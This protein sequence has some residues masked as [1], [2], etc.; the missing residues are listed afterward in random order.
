MRFNILR[1][2]TS[3]EPSFE[4]ELDVLRNHFEEISTRLRAEGSHILASESELHQ[5]QEQ[6][7]ELG[8]ELDS[9]RGRARFL[10]H[11]KE[12]IEI[13]IEQANRDIQKV[14]MEL[15]DSR[16]QIE[17][18]SVLV[19]SA[20]LKLEEVTSKCTELEAQ[21][22]RM[23]Q[24]Q[25][26]LSERKIVDGKK[27]EEETKILNNLY[28]QIE[29]LN[30]KNKVLT[31][32]C[33]KNS[34]E[35][36]N[37]S[38]E[39][40]NLRSKLRDKEVEHHDLEKKIE[41]VQSE[42][43][44]EERTLKSLNKNILEHKSEITQKNLFVKNFDD[45]IYHL[46][47]N[48]DEKQRSYEKLVRECEVLR[49]EASKKEE[50]YRE[51]KREMA[52]IK[53]LE[54][55][56]TRN[57]KEVSERLGF[58]EKE[59]RTKKEIMLKVQN[60]TERSLR[61]KSQDE[62]RILKV[63]SLIDQIDARNDDFS[64]Q[65]ESNRIG[66]YKTKKKLEILISEAKSKRALLQD[67]TRT[68]DATEGL[69]RAQLEKQETLEFE[70]GE[71]KQKAETQ[72]SEVEKKRSCLEAL[73]EEN[74]FVK[75]TIKAHKN[76]I[77]RYH[78]ELQA[79]K[80][81]V[82]IESTYLEKIEKEAE[83]VKKQDLLL[84][85]QVEALKVKINEF[86]KNSHI[87]DPFESKKEFKNKIATKTSQIEDHL[88]TF[89]H[90]LQEIDFTTFED[91]TLVTQ[92]INKVRN[93]LASMNVKVE[94]KI[95]NINS[96]NRKIKDKKN[97]LTEL[98]TNYSTKEEDLRSLLMKE[99]DLLGLE[100]KVENLISQEMDTLTDLEARVLSAN[101]QIKL[102]EVN[103]YKI[104]ESKRDQ[105]IERIDGLFEKSTKRIN[106]EELV[107]EEKTQNISPQISSQ[108]SVRRRSD[109]EV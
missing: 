108:R 74:R 27:V 66:V 34:Y 79:L 5:T 52:K 101:Q 32:I 84:V 4:A 95:E 49:I 41:R 16:S 7:R 2:K 12:N 21:F 60:D 109:I 62:S 38:T 83:E 73:K 47:Q 98:E 9:A 31:E 6:L 87:S 14:S 13:H 46:K 42:Y 22:K 65:K 39:V 75:D 64:R 57:K 85:S 56:G 82:Q 25:L 97:K 96:L 35:L 45:D 76:E 86:R 37:K 61:K 11:K 17:E 15:E 67:A 40:I 10:S 69:Y 107:S 78:K 81:E 18:E 68:F 106:T 3:I 105:L 53:S 54:A 51:V 55:E 59:L 89:F 63:Q 103:K 94:T 92:K 80:A 29:D 44:R 33:K 99:E 19:D 48:V 58:L 70:L 20:S 8:E 77:A 104:I 50:S 36:D 26:E 100:E 1:K 88:E 93:S 28:Q 43:E 90:L 23:K 71:V 72:M 30:S 102:L 91:L 24:S